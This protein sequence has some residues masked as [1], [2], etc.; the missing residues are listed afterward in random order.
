MITLS[1]NNISDKGAESIAT[2][3]VVNTSLHTIDMRYNH[4]R[5]DGAGKLAN[6]LITNHYS[7]KTLDLQY[8]PI[9]NVVGALILLDIKTKML[10]ANTEKDTAKRNNVGKNQRKRKISNEEKH[11]TLANEQEIAMLRAKLEA[12]DGS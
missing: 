8:N 5:D 11:I 10:I 9:S 3:L 2:S 4:I 1:N 12:L 7:I 6:A